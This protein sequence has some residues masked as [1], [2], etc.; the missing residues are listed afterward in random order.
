MSRGVTPL[1]VHSFCRESS[2]A[3]LHDVSP[4][5]IVRWANEAILATDALTTTRFTLNSPIVTLPM[6]T[7]VLIPAPGEPF[8]GL[9]WLNMFLGWQN[10]LNH[11]QLKPVLVFCL[12]WSR[13]E[14]DECNAEA[15][16]GSIHCS[17]N[18]A[19]QTGKLDLSSY[20][21]YLDFF[22]SN[23]FPVAE[24]SDDQLNI[25][26]RENKNMDEK[27]RIRAAYQSPTNVILVVTA[28]LLL[29]YRIRNNLFHGVKSLHALP[30]HMPLFDCVN[31]L[32]ATYIRDVHN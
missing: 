8:S 15:N 18:R 19:Y 28:L 29:T 26:C 7:T 32:L 22:R 13:F 5:F 10:H 11:E 30:N 12:L 9:D 3:R 24:L 31:G 6:P 17:V 27:E 23:Y 1:L 2:R 21:K 25:F 4:S 16:L 20:G 14:G